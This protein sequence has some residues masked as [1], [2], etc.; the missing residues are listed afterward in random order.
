MIDTKSFVTEMSSMT[1]PSYEQLIIH[2]IQGLPPELLAEV[3]DFVY[4]LRKRAMQP[5]IFEEERYA[6]LLDTELHQLDAGEL[7]HLES[8]IESYGQRYPE[9]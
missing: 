4:F 1:M 2:G 9:E 6:A 7:A 8:E 5:D 3:A